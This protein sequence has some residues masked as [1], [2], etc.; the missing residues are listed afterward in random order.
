MKKR[1]SVRGLVNKLHLWVGVPSALILFIVCLSGTVYVFNKEITRWVDK[2]KF[3]V[4][5]GSEPLESRLLI[6]KVENEIK[7]SRVAAITVPYRRNEAWTFS[8]AKKGKQGSVKATQEESPSKKGVKK[9]DTKKKEKLANYLVDPYT[10]KIQGNA[11]TTT[12]KFFN[13]V[14]ELHR[15][16][17]LD[18]EIGAIITGAAAFMFLFLEITGLILWLPSKIRNW[19]KWNAWKTGFKVKTTANWK[20]VNLD[21]HKMVGFYTFLVITVLALTG[22]VMGFEWYRKGFN[23]VMGAKPPGK[24]QEK[25]KSSTPSDPLAKSLTPEEWIARAN[26]IYAYNGDLRI[27]IPDSDSAAVTISKTHIGFAASAGVDRVVLDQYSNEAIKIEKF[28][29]KTLGQQIASMV[30]AIHTGESFGLLS[31]IISF[32][33][34]LFATCLPVTGVLIWLNKSKRKRKT[35]KPALVAVPDVVLVVDERRIV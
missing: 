33:A 16:L 2:E 5:E 35:L 23:Q 21:L 18:H 6:T 22:P 10:G 30:K 28:S 19:K 29:D 31:K 11:Q 9:E 4:Q 25:Y 24:V 1:L 34:C 32:I 27:S 14:M 15:W 20:R 13:T 12:S 17:L 7:D 26:S 8:L 3:Y